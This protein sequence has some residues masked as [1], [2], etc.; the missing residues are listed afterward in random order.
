MFTKITNVEA[1]FLKIYI[2]WFQLLINYLKNLVEVPFR[3]VKRTAAPQQKSREFQ[4][5]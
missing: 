2:S 3:W 1:I 5:I 4:N